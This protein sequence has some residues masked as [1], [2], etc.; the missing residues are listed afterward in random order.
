MINEFHLISNSA[1][2]GSIGMNY[3]FATNQAVTLNLYLG[4]GITCANCY[5]YIGGNIQITAQYSL[6]YG[7][8]F[9]ARITGS[10]GFNLDIIAQNPIFS[11][12]VT[13]PLLSPASSYSLIATILGITVSTKFGGLTATVSGSGSAS[14]TIEVNTG[15][16]FNAGLSFTYGYGGNVFFG[17]DVTMSP[18]YATYK[19]SGFSVN[20]A[21]MTV[22]LIPV[23]NLQITYGDGVFTGES[24]I[25]FNPYYQFVYGQ[26]GAVA[27]V[28]IDHS[29]S[30]FAATD[31][32]DSLLTYA[33]GDSIK[34]IFSYS[35]FNKQDLTIVHYFLTDGMVRY[36]IM[37]QNFTTSTMGTGTLVCYWAVPWDIRFF[38][39][40]Y[41]IGNSTR[42]S[43]AIE[44][45]CSNMFLDQYILSHMDFK[46]Q[47][48]RSF[49]SSPVDKELIL[50]NA[51]YNL[52]WDK[53]LLNYFH[54]ENTFLGGGSLKTTKFV[55]IYAYPT[56]CNVQNL[57]L[58]YNQRILLA[59]N[60]A[61]S[62]HVQINFNISSTE[63]DR[64]FF[65]YLESK[66]FRY[67]CGWSQSVF[68]VGTKLRTATAVKS[69]QNSEI[70]SSRLNA[71]QK[72]GKPV[73][74]SAFSSSCGTLN[75]GMKAAGRL[76]NLNF[77]GIPAL[78]SAYTSS[79]L[80]L[81]QGAMCV[82]INTPSPFPTNQ[83]TAY[84]TFQPS[85]FPSNM[86]TLYPTVQP[87]RLP[88]S[89]QP[90][91][92]PT[93]TP[94]I[95]PSSSPTILQSSLPSISPTSSPSILPSSLPSS[96][97]SLSQS[98]P[99]ML[100]TAAPAT[101]KPILQSS[102][103]RK[104]QVSVDVTHIFSNLSFARF[105]TPGSRRTL[106]AE[107]ALA[108]T[109]TPREALIDV[110]TTVL[111]GIN[112]SNVTI[113]TVHI[114]LGGKGIPDGV[115]IVYTVSAILE[116]TSFSTPD[117]FKSAVYTTISTS[118][119]SG[120]FEK[121]MKATTSALLRGASPSLTCR[122][123]APSVIYLVTDSPSTFPSLI[124]TSQPVTVNSKSG[125]DFIIIIIAVVTSIVGLIL[126]LFLF[127]FLC[128]RKQS[129]VR[130]VRYQQ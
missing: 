99:V 49:F 81:T 38:T 88:V 68:S 53:A 111:Q 13:I 114:L 122:V 74:K 108:T 36:P 120:N 90:T 8:G 123:G 31:D 7:F 55:N 130:P 48:S 3:N 18:P 52:T 70:S 107:P 127:Y 62:G 102:V 86:P 96:K 26:S 4:N 110:L 117:L 61:N 9:D 46:I 15:A 124:P 66:S 51:S 105:D 59:M 93:V 10:T 29:I 103:S 43:W 80:L 75:V 79:Y 106:L 33:P 116:S 87:T 42:D 73:S 119:T 50:Q 5:A 30:L 69:T 40:Y 113:G 77:I 109:L 12:S 67:S 100:V 82:T 125:N 25:L 20:Q 35:G 98:Q 95:L 121:T 104:T 128:R 89:N 65:L 118:L 64:S 112:P 21:T 45:R 28:F 92:R 85:K 14:G 91:R 83:P 41:T 78:G 115:E 23:I 2:P 94:S 63:Q 32:L 97:P 47:E 11:G 101:P 1:I 37:Q 34:I 84:P 54:V 56:S 6:T 57:E 24:S 129:S 19:L 60:I 22:S 76:D 16:S 39:D 126:F 72:K 71:L 17:T 44:V 27:S 58:C